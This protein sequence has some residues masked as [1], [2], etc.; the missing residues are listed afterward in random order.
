MR[1]M[2]WMVVI[3][4]TLVLA[5][6][7]LADAQRWGGKGRWGAW[8]ANYY[9]WNWNPATVE[10]LK[11]EVMTKDIITPPQGRSLLPAVGMTLKKEDDYA[12]YVH[13]GPEWYMDKQ[14]L[15]INVGDKVE[16]TG[17]RIM[18]E[19]NAVLL[20]SSIKKG[21][22]TWQFRD[23]QGFPYWSGRRW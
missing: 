8:S 17:S 10:T 16:V 20:V 18:V 23:P 19:G 5:T 21:D 9:H 13:L 12:I 14:E 2:K 22:K 1:S 4:A 7:T 3:V 6:F 11:G 15:D